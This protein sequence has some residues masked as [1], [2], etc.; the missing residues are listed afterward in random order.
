MPAKS[1]SNKS[2]NSVIEKKDADAD[3]RG[4][5]SEETETQATQET[6]D[7]VRTESSDQHEPKPSKIDNKTTIGNISRS[8]EI[9]ESR[10]PK[11]PIGPKKPKGKSRT[12]AKRTPQVETKIKKIDDIE[13]ESPGDEI[14]SPVDGT[15]IQLPVERYDEDGE[16]H[17]GQEQGDCKAGDDGEEDRME[18]HGQSTISGGVGQS[19]GIEEGASE[20]LDDDEDVVRFPPRPYFYREDGSTDSIDDAFN[21]LKKGVFAFAGLGLLF[22]AFK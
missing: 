13:R 21:Y 3:G 6:E 4:T 22:Q 2:R 12:S 14:K 10:R 7:Q 20:E 15:T 19:L 8:Y 5:V 17:G 1:K 16:G 9:L 11:K 18:G